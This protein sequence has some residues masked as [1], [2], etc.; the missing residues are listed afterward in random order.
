MFPSPSWERVA[1]RAS[2]GT[3]GEGEFL[4]PDAAPR[5][6]VAADPSPTSHSAL[7]QRSG[8]A[9]RSEVVLSRKG[10]AGSLLRRSAAAP[11]SRLVPHRLGQAAEPPAQLQSKRFGR[12]VVCVALAL[13]CFLHGLGPIGEPPAAAKRIAAAGA[14]P[15][16]RR[17]AAQPPELEPLGIEAAAILHC[18]VRRF[19]QTCRPPFRDAFQH[20]GRMTGGWRAEKR[21]PVAPHPLPDA[22]GASRRA[23][24]G[25]S[26]NGSAPGLAFR[27]PGFPSR[28]ASS[29]QGLIV[30]PGGAPMP[31]ECFMLRA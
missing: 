13:R 10:R 1:G 16:A 9:S 12:G 28:S 25:V 6:H 23:S 22:A 7:K 30:V 5:E 31:P 29:W 4:L 27:M 3:P 24:L 20:P 26:S 19:H 2:R 21:K 8:S 11:L 14:R 15:Q 17:V 18:P